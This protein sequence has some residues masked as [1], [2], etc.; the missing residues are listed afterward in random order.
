[1]ARFA[2]HTVG[3]QFIVLP[4][5]LKFTFPQVAENNYIDTLVHA[6]LKKLRIAPSAVCSDEEFLRRASID[7]IGLLPTRRGISTRS[8]PTRRPTSGPRLVDELSTRKEFAE[9]WVTKWAELLQ[10]RTEPERQP[11]G[12]VPLLQLAAGQDRQQHADG[13]DGP[14]AA[15]RQGGTFKNPATNFYQNETDTLTLTENV[16]Q[17]FM[18]M[19]IQCAQCHNHP[20]DRWTRTTTTASR[21]SSPRSAARAEDHRETI[22]F[23]SGGGEVNHPVDG[24]AMKPKFLGGRRPT[25]PARTAAWCWP[26]GW[27]RPRTPGS[28]TTSPTSVW[29]HFFG[30]GSSSRST[31]SASATRPSTPSCSTRWASTSPSTSTTSRRWCATSATRGPIS[32]RP[33]ATR[34][35][36][37]DHRNFAHAGAPPDQGREHARHH[38]RGDRHQGQVP[39]PAA[40]RPGRADRRRQHVDLLP[41]DLRPGHPRDGL[42]VRGQ[43]GA[44][45]VAGPAPAQRRHGEQ[46]RSTRAADRPAFEGKEN[47]ARDSRRVVYPLP[48]AAADRKRTRHADRPLGGTARTRSRRS[49]TSSG[50][51]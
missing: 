1:M 43:D 8:W 18:G 34:R 49:K 37:G 47:A 15:R 31:T 25:S 40:G 24:R 26:S 41:H 10:I 36:D 16:A 22:V 7:I 5:G 27:P 28:P 50:P 9:I 38:Q 35:N 30:R 4:K 21:R 2:T 29:A 14:G 12:D 46:R 44:D 3:S 23:N 39:R 42:L 45:P 19:R 51:C 13:R 20:F 6:K 33:R 11:E 48:L 32:A 17:V